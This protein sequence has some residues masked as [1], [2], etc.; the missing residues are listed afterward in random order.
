MIKGNGDLR[1]ACATNQPYRTSDE[2]EII[3]LMENVGVNSADVLC[4]VIITLC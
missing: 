3:I 2:K 4:D 1:P